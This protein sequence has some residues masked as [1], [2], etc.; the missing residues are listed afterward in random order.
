[1]THDCAASDTRTRGLSRSSFNRRLCSVSRRSLS[2]LID[3]FP[4]LGIILDE[5]NG[6]FALEMCS[7]YSCSDCLY[8]PLAHHASSSWIFAV[9]LAVSRERL[10]RSLFDLAALYSSGDSCRRDRV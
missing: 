7:F 9:L 1:M 5:G 8:E 3:C 2:S 4:V 6:G 10:V